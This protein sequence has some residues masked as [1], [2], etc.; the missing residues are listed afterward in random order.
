MRAQP[1]TVAVTAFLSIAM[2]SGAA[3]AAGLGNLTYAAGELH[4]SVSLFNDRTNMLGGPGGADSVLMLHGLLIVLGTYDS[5]KGGSAFHVFDVSNPRSPVKVKTYTSALTAELAEWHMAVMG[6]VNGKDILLC[7]TT[8]G[9]AFFDFTDPLNPKDVSKLALPGV[10]GGDYTNTAWMNSWS[11]PYVFTANSGAG[12]SIT[13]ATDPANPKLV[14]QIP[15]GQMGNFRVGPVV[16]AGNNLIVTNMDEAPLHVSVLDVGD[17]QN[18]AL[19]NTVTSPAGLYDAAVI[20]DWVY[21]AGDKAQYTFLKWSEASTKVVVQKTIGVDKGAYCTYQDGFG[22]CGQSADGFHKIDMRDPTNI[23]DTGSA[24]LTQAEAPNGDFDFATV[25]GNLV[26]QGNDHGSGSGL[27]VLQTAPDTTPPAVVKIYP[28]D[29]ATRQ[30]KTTRVTV[31]FSDEVDTD[32]ISDT[33]VIVRKVGGAP[34]AGVYTH[35]STNAI[36]FGPMQPLEANMT[37]EIA[38]VPGAVKD[39]VGNA[40]T[41]A[42]TSRF[43]TGATVTP[44]GGGTTGG[45]AGGTAATATGGVS[46]GGGAAGSTSPGGNVEA[47]GRTGVGGTGGAINSNLPGAGGSAEAGTQSAAATTA[48]SP[49]CACSLPGERSGSAEAAWLAVAAVTLGLQRRRVGRGCA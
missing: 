25:L 27:L 26:F 29:Q 21:G 1:R 4:K 40:L 23:V 12:V 9:I 20:G 13:D 5:G 37:Y 19:L 16:A 11:W 42:A 47:G 41:E 17:V 28:L 43:S 18:T 36:S 46:G 34:L 32:T 14:K 2:V 45:G 44:G 6:K 22:I 48:S 38:V 3:G 30:P 35:S 7:R 15:V 8:T 49:G 24:V 33:S 10:N 31:F 39:L